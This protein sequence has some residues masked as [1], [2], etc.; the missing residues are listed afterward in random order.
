M[1]SAISSRYAINL[2]DVSNAAQ[3]IKEL[4][5]VTP[6]VKLKLNKRSK[7]EGK[8]ETEEEDIVYLKC[9]GL[10]RG[11][12]F[13]FRGAC[14]SV[15]ALQEER[16]ASGA[17]GKLSVVTH[18]SGNHAAALALAASLN[19]AD[20]HVVMPD[21]APECKK[22]A[23]IANGA[24]M[25]IYTEDTHDNDNQHFEWFQI[26]V[27]NNRCTCTI[28]SDSNLTPTV[29]S[30][31]NSVC[32]HNGSSRSCCCNR[33]VFNWRYFNSAIQFLARYGWP[34]H[35]CLGAVRASGKPRLHYCSSKWS[36]YDQWN[37]YCSKDHESE[38]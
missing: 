4:A 23:A 37:F 35:D 18:S 9:E 30:I 22:N 13:K 2:A 34:R 27:W 8:D 14:N 5:V 7:N 12:S 10:Q 26:A 36:R 24:G 32:K 1:S 3:R 38:N 16:R 11:G 19:G 28:V 6:V 15:I 21:T 17:S 20:A 33:D 29:D 25:K 31:T